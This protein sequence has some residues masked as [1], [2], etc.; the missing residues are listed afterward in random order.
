MKHAFAIPVAA[1][2]AALAV[3]LGAWTP[4]KEAVV[5]K[6]P[7]SKSQWIWAADKPIQNGSAACFRIGFT[8][9]SPAETAFVKVNYDDSGNL[10]L[11]GKSLNGGKG[12]KTGT[13]FYDLSKLPKVGR[14][15]IAMEVKNG[16]GIAGVL[17]FGEVKMKNGKTFF[18]HTD[19]DTKSVSGPLT[20]KWYS[21]DFD[22]AKWGKSLVHGD[23][24][25]PPWSKYRDLTGDFLTPDERRV[26]NAA[27]EKSRALPAKLAA[28]KFQP[29]SILYKDGMPWFKFGNELQWPIFDLTGGGGIYEDS[30]VFRHGQLGMRVFQVGQTEETFLLRD[31][32][33][34]FDRTDKGVRRVLNL[35][36]DAKICLYFRIAHMRDFCKANPDETIKFGTGPAD[37]DDELRGRPVRPSAASVK[38]RQEITRYLKAL[39][40]FVNKQPWAKRVVGIRVCYGIYSEWHSYGMYH[41]PDLSKPMTAAF[42][43]WLKKK[44]KTDDA[45]RKA[46]KDAK[47]TIATAQVPTVQERWGKDRFFR[48]PVADAK[49]L[50]FY[51]CYADTHADLL[52][53]MA[54][55]AKELFPGR[56]CGAYYGYALCNHPPEGSTVLLDKIAS[57]PY[58][59]FISSPPP[60]TPEARL[61]GGPN[62]SRSVSATLA[63]YG[64]ILIIEDDSRFH[65]IPGFT[66]K[67][68]SMRSPLESRMTMRRNMLNMLFEPCGTQLADPCSGRDTRPGAFDDPAVRQGLKESLAV[69]GKALPLPADSGNEIAAVWNYMERL[70]HYASP[71]SK[72]LLGHIVNNATLPQ[73]YRS[74][75]TFDLL[76]MTD[77]ALTKKKY[78]A[79]VFLNAFTLSAKEREAIKAKMR[80]P[81]TAAVF[82]NGAGYVTPEGLSV[83]A[84]SDLTGMKI[85]MDRKGKDSSLKFAK[86]G[87]SGTHN[88]GTEERFYVDDPA[89]ESFG[90][91]VADKK[92]GAA[93]KKLPGGAVSIYAGNYPRTGAQWR[94]L[95]LKTGVKP[96]ASPGSYVRRRGD[97]VMFHTGTKGKHVITFPGKVKGATELFTG[98]KSTGN[99]VT[100]NSEEG[101]GTWL[102]K[103]F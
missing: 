36:P 34:N 67:V 96:L 91:Y 51:A 54:K 58:V 4:A 10:W 84:V 61:A 56:L 28:E 9:D 37:S 73:L 85:A 79:V 62:L 89:A 8:L 29:A 23:V 14:N 92:V 2:L 43:A 86:S 3:P 15:V 59:D 83:K 66:E 72:I 20:G 38:L 24:I 87:L 100:V 31:G 95:L 98:T 78:K 103:T 49:E 46:W 40:E 74:G 82:F 81:G 13:R 48:D 42:R 88:R 65:H 57:S 97:L 21:P 39:A 80:Q 94:E 12:L 22:D 102:F 75:F 16:R 90:A 30:W 18:L 64:K 41:A 33:L 101:P 47:V 63:R 6:R 19:A 25:A 26:Y 35:V 55:T 60:Y 52:L 93:L 53:F 99:T 71:K 7:V 11:N 32:S 68:I 50:D 45:L 27:A 5:H 17:L 1:L 76:S 69:M 77:F 44:Y 70:R